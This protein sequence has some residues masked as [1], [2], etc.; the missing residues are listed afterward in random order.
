MVCL[1]TRNQQIGSATSTSSLT[2][3]LHPKVTQTFN[4]NG[5]LTVKTVTPEDTSPAG[6]QAGK[7]SQRYTYSVSERL[8]R[9]SD[10]SGVAN[11]TN[12]A[13]TANNEQGN[14][15]AR[16]AYDP[17]GRR[18]KKTVSQNPTGQGSTGTT[19]YFYADEGLIAEVDGNAGSTTLG[20][21]T[22][23]YGWVPASA[24]TGTWGTAP[25]WKRD[26][27]GQSGATNPQGDAS[28][29]GVE[30]YYHVDHLGTSQRLTNAQGETTW[31]MVSEAF[32]K[33]FVD[34]TLAPT[35]T[36]TT[37]N[38]LRFPGQYEDV[39]TGTYYNF[40]RTYLPMVGRYG[41]SDPIG[42]SGGINTFS[43]VEGNPLS[44]I[45][46][47]GLV[48]LYGDGSVTMNAYPGPPAGG[49]E[50]A[51]AG[52]G[53]NYHVHIR[54]S[55]GREVRISTETW[56]PLTPQDQKIYD[57]SKPIRNFCDGLS[58]G[59]KKFYDRVNRQVFHKGYP[60]VNQAV[61]LGG[62]RGR[63]GGR[64]QE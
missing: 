34:T 17:F 32:G 46:P 39:E 64:S 55:S 50:H 44:M 49:N 13:N 58:P 30:H 41:E 42:L 16:Y 23:T 38:N 51:R 52:A 22:T 20:N 1:P 37:T 2:S 11:N 18:I 63:T 35:T 5:H 26:H 57:Q 61:R 48:G 12:T 19:L 62:W 3:I 21:I 7:Q 25:Q 4:A 27:A 54:D 14:E 36:G 33:T 15:I 28:T 6:L 8:L 40:M 45:D 9:I 59:E 47:E 56:K 10:G 53:Q 29:N 60:T 31:R 24:N 43:Y